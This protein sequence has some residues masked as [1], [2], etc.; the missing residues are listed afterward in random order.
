VARKL[1]LPPFRDNPRIEE[2]GMLK[3]YKFLEESE[4]RPV[5]VPIADSYT[6]AVVDAVAPS[7]N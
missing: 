6:N 5:T 7:I 4:Q 2:K 3:D 1:S